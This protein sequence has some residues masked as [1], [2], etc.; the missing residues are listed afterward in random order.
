MDS[1]TKLLLHCE[2]ADASTTF[3]DSSP[4]P[5]TFTA[6]GNA[7]IDTAQFKFGAASILLDGTGDYLTGDGSADFAFGSGDFTFDFWIRINSLAS[8]QILYDS[9]PA[10]TNGVY[11]TL[12]ISSNTL[13][14]FVSGADRITGATTLSINTWY[15]IAVARSGTSTKLF[16]NGTQE[17]STY[18]DSNSYLN[19][20]N[21]PLIGESGN[22]A[23][24]P[25]N[26]WVDEFR[27]SKGIARWTADFTP[28]TRAYADFSLT[29]DQG[30]FA[31]NG[32]DAAFSLGFSFS[33]DHGDFALSGQDATLRK[34]A[35]NLTADYG[36]FALNGQDAT[37]SRPIRTMLADCGEF[38]LIGQ[39]AELRRRWAG[40]MPF[41]SQGLSLVRSSQ[42]FA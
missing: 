5:H 2:G 8:T 6:A 33:A 10:S 26:G 41:V 23:G 24:N 17:G 29:S 20:A 11:T 16:L 28:P 25:I 40:Q 3:T 13:K 9:R 7:Q 27:I 14:F 37:F 30:S 12:Y 21:R 39:D 36:A 4:S 38:A 1:F 15:H 32:Q 22:T 34:T 42:L 31:L 19:P 18:S 35:V